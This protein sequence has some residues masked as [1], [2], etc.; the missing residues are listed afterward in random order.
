[1][2]YLDKINGPSDIKNL[3][4]SELEILAKEI[5]EKIIDT[6]S[7]TGGH[8]APSL[9][10]VELAIAAHYV[11]ESP[12]DKIIWDVGHQ[13]YA[14]KLLTGR[15][16]DFHTLRTYGGISGFLK[17]EESEHDIFAAGHSST[18]VS[19][20]AGI[21][22]G[23]DILGDDYKVLSI[24]GDGSLT[25]GM[26][27]EAMNHIGH[28]KKNLTLVLNDN[29]MSIAPNVGAL[30]KYLI[31]IRNKP[32]YHKLEEDANA[33]FK[34]LPPIGKNMLSKMTKIKNNL[35]H[36]MIPGALFEEF[37]FKYFGPIDGHDLRELILAFKWIKR[38]QGPVL[39]HVLTKKGKGFELAEKNPE[40]FHGVGPFDV[41][42]GTISKKKKPSFTSVFG[43]ELVKIAEKNKKV[44]AI[45]AAMPLGTGLAGFRDKFQDRYFDVGICEQHAVTFAAG[46]VKAGLKPVVAVY[47]SFMQRAMDQ[48]I[49][50]VA[51]QKLPVVFALDRAGI[52][53]QDGG[54]HHG[55]F[56]LTFMRMIP[57]MVISAP[58]NG[59]QLRD[60]L[61]FAINYNEGPIAI[62]YQRG[63]IPENSLS[64][65]QKI[66]LGKG[67]L[68]KKGNDYLIIAVGRFVEIAS[69]IIDELKNYSGSLINPIFIKPLDEELLISKIKSH[70]KVIVIEENSTIGGL[71]SAILELCA[72]KNISNNIKS[73][74]IP[75]KFVTHGDT[76]EVLN[77]IIIIKCKRVSSRFFLN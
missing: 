12:K 57:N 73:I 37:G 8:L 28:L 43:N 40:L 33:L 34:M 3:K 58:K 75:D 47:S 56:D 77:E 39:L 24:I 41:S 49:H 29:D 19:A 76:N 64:E 23:R 32:L 61:N 17:P 67:E 16:K 9:G 10:C 68:L 14:H 59:A 2:K 63:E 48:V 7:K 42:T 11:Y 52:V 15:F 38:L 4:L 54:T 30:S 25:A 46:L 60:L 72:R 66:K 53:G 22:A 50:D 35:K 18:S 65:P 45:T 62:R 71:G 55:V 27:Y 51:M 1:M 26:A 74:G 31:K 6:V 20:G 69:Q 13:A 70:E 5:R 44:V 21:A 36:L